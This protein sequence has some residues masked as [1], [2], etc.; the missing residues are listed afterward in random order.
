MR[1]PA[2]HFGNSKVSEGPPS[3]SY[4]FGRMN[5]L[6]T[7]TKELLQKVGDDKLAPPKTAEFALILLRKGPDRERLIEANAQINTCSVSDAASLARRR[8]P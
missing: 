4:S 6:D 3:V 2:T 8:A 1:G 7:Q 5:W